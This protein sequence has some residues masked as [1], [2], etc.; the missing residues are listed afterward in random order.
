MKNRSWLLIGFLLVLGCSPK[1]T[2]KPGPAVNPLS[3]P[4]VSASPTPMAGPQAPSLVN[5]HPPV[6]EAQFQASF[7]KTA[8]ADVN[9]GNLEDFYTVAQYQFNSLDYV[10]CLKTYQKMLHVQTSLPQLDK[11]QYMVGQVYFEKK[12]YLA[13]MAAFQSLM[14]KYP[15]SLYLEQSGKMMEFILTYSLTMEDLSRFVENYPDSP[16]KCSALFQLGSK[17][18][19]AAQQS[20]SIAHLNQFIQQCPQ[21]SM[22]P[23]A[24]LL[25]QSMQSLQQGKTWKVG[26]LVPMTGRFKSFGESVLNGVTLAVEQA[27]KN[28]GSKKPMT[29]LVRDTTGDPIQAVKVFQ[30]LTKDNS[31]DAVIGPVVA[32]EIAAVAPLANQQ[33]ITLITPSNS[34]DGLSGL[35]PYLFSNSMTNEMQGRAI[36]HYAVEKLGFKSFGILAPDD[37]YG[38][39]LSNAFEKTVEAIGGTVTASQIYPPSA[40]DFKKQ[41]IA[42]GG[43]DPG[44]SKENDRENA[45]RSDELNYNLKKEIGKVLIKA[46]DLMD[47]YPS[48][49]ENNTP[50]LT[51]VAL[52]PLVENLSNTICPSI[53]KDVNTTIRSAFQDQSDFI[54]RNDD[55]VQQ[56]MTSLPSEP[57]GTTLTVTADQWG[58]IARS[59]RTSLLIT[60]KIV[61]TNPANDWNPSNPTWDYTLSLEAYQLN[62]LKNNYF[63]IYQSRL[64]YSPFKPASMVRSLASYQAL[65]LPAHSAEIPLLVSQ[66]H[67]Y[68]L[69]PV[70]LGGHL[71]ENQTVL[72]EG[73]KDL[74]GSYFV[75]GFYTD[76]QQAVVKRFSEDYLRRFTKR[77]DLLSAQSYDA[78]R[79]LLG[80]LSLSL[81]RDS[82]HTLLSQVRD[83]EGVSGRTTFGG[84]GEADKM[85]PILKIQGGKYEQVQ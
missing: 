37:G 77:P 63:R 49:P 22:V 68:D 69:N 83:F 64:T 26:V 19:Q 47:S 32:S 10:D 2:V 18:A 50:T 79:L 65:Y 41:I 70:F 82:V 72:Q 85:V 34:R 13:A 73:V 67:F 8:Q 6:S 75:S 59:I 15:K 16:S 20:D 56:A 55:L 23:S 43:Q 61:E 17:E 53:G 3:Q 45:R 76:S 81:D 58:E 51:A 52:V 36:A 24:Q 39:T 33:K 9:S 12:D 14:D 42:L 54:L 11:A 28:G 48:G 80:A 84:Q 78:A 1:E 40:T 27:N 7:A 21:H 60:G 66:I 44:Y 74:E 29:L 31:L 4:M 35:G 5:I 57:K 25:L 46:K 38:E 71:W 62:P 30:E